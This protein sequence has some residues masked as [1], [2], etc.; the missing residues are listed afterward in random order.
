M[1]GHC[2]VPVVAAGAQM[3][4]DALALKKDLDGR[5]ASATSTSLRAKTYGTL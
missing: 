4:G 1:L 5:A 2:G 3:S